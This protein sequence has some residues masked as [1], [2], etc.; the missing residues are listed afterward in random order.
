[1][2]QLVIMG[3]PIFMASSEQIKKYLAYWF[4]VGKPMIL[5]RSN[6]EILPDP[7]VLGDRYSPEFRA[8]YAELLKPENRDAYLQGTDQTIGNLLSSRW[9]IVS[10]ARCAMPIALDEIGLITGCPCSDLDAWPNTTLPTP[11]CPKN[12]RAHLT[13]IHERLQSRLASNP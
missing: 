13:L 7:V 11:R 1:M 4:Q 3:Y 8:C 10:C 9:E 6:R 2:H 5:P 12:V